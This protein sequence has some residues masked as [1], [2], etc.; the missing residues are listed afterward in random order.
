MSSS[1]DTRL[2]VGEQDGHAVRG[3]DAERDARKC[4]DHRVGDRK[5]E[6]TRGRS[7]ELAA[8]AVG[9]ERRVVDHHDIGRVRLLEGRDPPRTGSAA[10]GS[11]VAAGVVEVVGRVDWAL[12]GIWLPG[13]RRRGTPPSKPA[14]MT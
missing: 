5:A 4:G 3:T 13:W 11:G 14:A 7:P 1:D 6:T 2:R 8:R 10:T 9:G 12:V